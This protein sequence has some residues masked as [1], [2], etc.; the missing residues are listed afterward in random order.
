MCEG[1]HTQAPT[2]S[3]LPPLHL[4][5]ESL[6]WVFAGCLSSPLP[7]DSAFENSPVLFGPRWT[8]LPV[9]PVPADSPP[10]SAKAHPHSFQIYFSKGY[11]AWPCN[12]ESLFFIP[13]LAIQALGPAH[14]R[15]FLK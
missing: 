12:V 4:L 14:L 7:S 5:P 6:S 13:F 15:S 10:P 1:C 3:H 2:L 9:N 8:H 11:S